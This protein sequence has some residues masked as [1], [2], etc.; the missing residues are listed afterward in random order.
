MA[1]KALTH[2]GGWV[3]SG[4]GS[5][6]RI[7]EAPGAIQ[8][9][10]IFEAEFFFRYIRRPSALGGDNAQAQNLKQPETGCQTTGA[11]SSQDQT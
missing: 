1:A 7:G 8:G 4:S 5:R 11:T 10:V 2:E 9:L 3:G 6:I